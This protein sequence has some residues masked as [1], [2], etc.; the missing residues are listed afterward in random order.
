[1]SGKK[2]I[3]AHVK[4]FAVLKQLCF[5]ISFNAF[6][7]YFQMDEG[8]VRRAFHAFCD[9]VTTSNDEPRRC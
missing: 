3:K 8:T 4:V 2:K 6:T 7:D 5:G 9:D 1:L